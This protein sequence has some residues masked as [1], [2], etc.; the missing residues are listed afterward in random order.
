[1]EIDHG[2]VQPLEILFGGIRKR[3]V[4][5]FFVNSV[6]P[7]FAPIRRVHR[8]GRAVV[9]YLA[10]LDRR[11]LLIGSGGSRTNRR[12]PRSTPHPR[13]WS[14]GIRAEADAARADR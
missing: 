13:T 3:Q 1:M 6:A 5:P 4:V 11:V 9:S 14:R 8:L 12:C 10:T 7:P 2:A